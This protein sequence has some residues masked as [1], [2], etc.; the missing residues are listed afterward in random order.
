MLDEIDKLGKSYQGDPASALLEVLDPEQNSG[1]NDHYLDLDYDLSKVMFIATANNL[2]GIP[3]PLR[4]RMEIIEISGY[5][6][7]EKLNIARR[8]LIP[9]QLK[10]N[11][12]DDI[13]CK[14]TD[15]AIRT[16]VHK[17]TREAG[18]RNLERE[19]ASVCR[20]VAKE[21][22]EKRAAEGKKVKISYRINTSKV[23]SLLGPPKYKFNKAEENDEI[24]VTNGLAV[25][26]A[27]GDLLTT[28]VSLMPGTGQLKLTGNL[29]KVME[30]SAHAALSYVR[31]KA[32]FWG[33]APG[34]H[35]KI[36]IHIHF[37]E[38]AIPKDGPSAGITMATSLVSALTR[39]PVRKDVA[40]TGEITLRGR[41]LPIGGL[42]E[43]VLAAHRAGVKTV[44]CPMENKKDIRDIPKVVRNSITIV[45]VEHMDEV[46][47]VAL[48]EAIQHLEGSHDE[49]QDPLIDL[50]MKTGDDEPKAPAVH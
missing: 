44:L 26:M 49:V 2:H 32:H 22:I 9:K 16:L 1:F 7:Y 45:T 46:I 36:D 39:I 20:K 42:K 19:T 3:I 28:E 18:V 15:A 31:S 27:G 40:M 48:A 43:K 14:W 10:D 30:E 13:E 12:I 50:L 38:G 24:G 25:T 8:Y 33:L 23:T 37:P 5:T 17:Y 34:F 11:G 6:E 4:D 21:V 35:K 29:A 47:P 41:V